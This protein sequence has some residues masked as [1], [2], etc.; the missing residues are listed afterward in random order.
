V[1]LG[2]FIVEVSRSHSDTPL[3]VGLLWTSDRPFAEASTW[4]HTTVTRD[5]Q[6]CLRVDSNTE[7]K[8]A[9]SRRPTQKA[10][11]L[12]SV[13]FTVRLCLSV[14]GSG[15]WSSICVF[16]CVHEHTFVHVTK[17]SYISNSSQ[18]LKRSSI[19]PRRI[20]PRLIFR[21]LV[22]WSNIFEP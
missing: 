13:L 2:L 22:I 21:K 5:K 19:D 16:I 14:L 6:P 4:Q 7:S 11:P 8:S 20:L 15:V 9:S 10:R 12:E 17:N 1:V 3:S 18:F